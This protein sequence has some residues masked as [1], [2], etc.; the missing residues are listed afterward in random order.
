[1]SSTAHAIGH[2]GEI[3]QGMFRDGSGRLHRG[4]V[5]LPF[6]P[7]MTIAKVSISAD[8]PMSISPPHK[9]KALSAARALCRDLDYQ[10]PGLSIALR[11]NIPEGYGLGSSTADVVAA[12]R[13]VAG[14]LG[15]RIKASAAFRRAIAAE[16]ASDSTMF[17]PRARLVCQREGLVLERYAGALPPFSL[18]SVNVA[19]DQPVD[20]LLLPPA[21][22]SDDEVDELADLRNA[23]RRAVATC[24][25][26][27]L[28]RAA[29][30]SMELNQRRLP[31]PNYTAIRQIAVDLKA[32][33]IQV[34]HSG[35]MMGIMLG[36]GA[37]PNG[38]R[39]VAA[40]HDLIDLGLL[41][42]FYPADLLA[43]TR[44]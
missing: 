37:S 21:C 13:A 25:V 12:L 18:L 7:C 36:P 4:L 33:G 42:Q 32:L 15:C 29:T 30:R 24:D 40:Q 38:R 27:L 2:H 1:M 14:L 10:G 34:A 20:T 19:P 28:A 26:R 11:S 17:G 41:P 35:R 23:V 6:P 8:C 44:T 3:L 43:L 22:Y 16:T 39:I 31:Q 9:L 5:S